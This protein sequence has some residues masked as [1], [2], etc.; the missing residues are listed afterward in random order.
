MARSKRQQPRN[1]N[2][3]FGDSPATAPKRKC[4]PAQE[5]HLAKLRVMAIHLAQH[6]VA[7]LPPLKEAK[8]K[9]AKAEP[10]ET[11]PLETEP[12]EAEP[13][14]AEQAEPGDCRKKPAKP[15]PLYDRLLGKSDGVIDGFTALAQVVVRIVDQERQGLD[16]AAAPDLPEQDEQ[17][18]G[19]RITAE[20]ARLA[21]RRRAAG[22][23]GPDDPLPGG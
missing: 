14:K 7:Q 5:K 19:H 2:G 8:E 18:L 16:F 17:A 1:K 11:E 21:A 23:P 10:L 15:P 9:S 12:L 6:L 20:L 3:T 22:F 4:K 13:P